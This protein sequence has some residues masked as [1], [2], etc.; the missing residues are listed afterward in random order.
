MKNNKKALSKTLSIFNSLTLKVLFV[1]FL[2][3]L[4]DSLCA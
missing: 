1:Y 2:R 4:F 3:Y